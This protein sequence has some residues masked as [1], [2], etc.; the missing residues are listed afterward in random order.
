MSAWSVTIA[1][2]RTRI[3]EKAQTLGQR[4]AAIIG[5]GILVAGTIQGG[6]ALEDAPQIIAHPRITRMHIHL[7]QRVHVPGS[8][9]GTSQTRP[10]AAAVEFEQEGAIERPVVAAGVH[11]PDCEITPGNIARQT[12]G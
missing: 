5:Q 8:L 12:Q 3:I 11:C 10:V 1:A 2:S 9:I 4:I 7:G 6:P